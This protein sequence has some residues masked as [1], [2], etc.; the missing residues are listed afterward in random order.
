[1]DIPWAKTAVPHLPPGYVRRPRLLAA[2]ERA[3]PGQ[4]VVV[5]A[6]AGYGK[7]LLL[8]EWAAAHPERT[9][10][11]CLDDDD[12]T[13]HRLWSAVL[14]A[15]RGCPAV[16]ADSGLR[17][18]APPGRPA[19]GRGF[20][21]ALV[22]AL[23]A[24]PGEVAL[25]L[26][27]VHELVSPA[28]LHALAAL[29]RD[30]PAPLRLVL[31]SRSDPPVSIARL[32]LDGQ[33]CEVRARDLAFSTEEAGALLAGAAVA[34]VPEKVRVLVDE[35]A[36]WAA[37][38]RLAALSMRGA[39]DP[40]AFLGDLVGNSK[41]VSDYLV[42]EILSRLP[43]ATC[44]LLEALSVCDQLSADL[45]A[46][47]SGRADAGDVLAALEVETS[48]VLSSGEGRTCY[49]IHPLLRAHLSM[50]LHRRRPT[51]VADLHR[52]AADWFAH[53]GHAAAALQHAR[54]A[55]DVALVTGLARRVAVALVADGRHAAVAAALELV[56]GATPDAHLALVAA[57]VAVEAGATDGAAAH[58][59]RAVDGW[60]A[61]PAPELVALLAAVRLRM[62]TATGAPAAI[63]RAAAEFAAAAQ[64]A[65]PDLL[66]MGRVDVAFGHLVAQR[67]EE[68]RR[69]AEAVVGDARR[70]ERR[71]LA[72][73]ALGTMAAAARAVGDYRT[74]TALAERADAEL[75]PCGWDGTT[76]GAFV[77]TLRAYGSWL[78]AAPVR[79]LDLL[80]RPP[81]DAPSGDALDALR[82][83][84]RAAAL[85]DIG[86]GPEAV[87]EL[88]LGCAALARQVLSVELSAAAALL[89]HGTATAL[90]RRETAAELLRAARG[91]P[92][93]SP[94]VARLMALRHAVADGG[95]RRDLDAPV[96]ALLDPAVPAPVRWVRTE[97]AVLACGVALDA[98]RLPQAR[99][100]L[101]LALC[102]A[103]AS[104]A[105]RPLLTAAPAV[106]DLLA[107]QIGS[108]GPGDAPGSRLLELRRRRTAA[109]QQLTGRERDVLDLLATQASLDDIAADLAIAPS[110]VKT[111]VRAIYTKLGVSS[112]RAAVTAGR[113]G[114]RTPG[115]R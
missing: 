111:H 102:D 87:P 95:V 30:R 103:A 15:L 29:V 44:E 8:A 36:G 54:L 49:R 99:A 25:V 100:D 39:A 106:V 98:G 75:A 45:A 80:G 107:R 84:L 10:W 46:A 92:S 60:P 58:L 51:A 68:A 70:R 64:G 13:E 71:F 61:D 89:L 31:S 96:R 63:G 114:V 59:A 94:Q 73:R 3:A 72:A 37:G 67:P 38:L 112:R 28:P 27:D 5:S 76:T 110:T 43:A 2:L 53:H 20:V 88:R 56:A 34:M 57:L 33:V 65:D 6:P 14:A 24:L 50:S 101:D 41:A 104:G 108:F 85:A 17:D 22:A 4:V 16:P 62:A 19:D 66:L 42:G 82:H 12:T 48:L 35:T 81:D 115:L 23:E 78:D 21:T 47:L 105:V 52:R 1:M 83:A 91:S 113:R 93:W 69:L 97:A 32:R 74:M 7:T 109:A 55:G 18:L 79:C 26:D 90:G 9:A 86:R 40:D 11:V 77:A